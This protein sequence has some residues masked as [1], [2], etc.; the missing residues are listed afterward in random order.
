[1]AELHPYLNFDGTCREAMTF[2]Q[3]CLGGDLQLMTFGD[4]PGGGVP[5]GAED[6]IMH[7]TLTSGSLRLLASDGRPGEAPRQGDSV[8][9][10][11]NLQSRE[12]IDSLFVALGAGGNVTMPLGDMPWGG[13]F[14][15]LVDRF[16]M[17]WMFHFDL[18][19][20]S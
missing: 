17:P 18:T 2:Y 11:L 1:M 3:A 7:S 10:S 5:P 13:R 12:E 19:R 8:H 14:G 20:Q 15:M 16:G 4:N 9:L 6:R